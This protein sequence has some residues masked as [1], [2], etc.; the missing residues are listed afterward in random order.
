MLGIVTVNWNGFEMTR[1]L[2]EQLLESDF[3]DF[4][5]AV[6]N[7]SPEERE[8]FETCS[9]FQ[10]PRVMVIHSPVNAGYSGG[11]NT[12]LKSL[13]PDPA[14]DHFLLMNNDVRIGPEFLG[15]MLAEG[16]SENKIYAPLILLKDTSLV[17]NSGGEIHIWLGGSINL[18]KN[19]PIEKIQKRQPGYLGGCI[20]F[21]HRKVIE[22]VGLFDEKFGSYFEDADYCL[23]AKAAGIAGEVLWDITAR[24]F[25]SYSTQEKNSYKIFLINRNQIYFARKHLAPLP[26]LVFITAAI[27]RGFLMNSTRTRFS[28]FMRGIIEGFHVI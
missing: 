19:V 1:G 11:L 27:V 24:H 2:V 20:L 25:H 23:R 8:Q 18:N 17:Q 7:N 21:A 12:G 4:R 14:V 5:L 15:R 28:P 16:Q 3:Q 10:D 13:L 9:L 6:V 26:R 22:K